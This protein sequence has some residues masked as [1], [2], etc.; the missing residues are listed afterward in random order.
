MSVRKGFLSWMMTARQMR[1]GE[2]TVH[3][4]QRSTRKNQEILVLFLL[5]HK[6]RYPILPSPNGR[7]GVFNTDTLSLERASV[8]RGGVSLPGKA[9]F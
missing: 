8:N 2:V 9:G 1:L 7:Y 4:E 3:Q 6:R 5:T